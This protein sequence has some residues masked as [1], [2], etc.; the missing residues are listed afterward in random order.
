MAIVKHYVLSFE[1]SVDEPKAVELLESSDY[2]KQ[3]LAQLAV[4]SVLDE[5]RSK[6]HLVPLY[7]EHEGVAG[8]EHPLESGDVLA[9]LLLSTVQDLDL[10]VEL[11]RKHVV[12]IEVCVAPEPKD[13][14][15][16]DFGSYG[17]V[18]ALIPVA[19][20]DA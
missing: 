10:A 8:E 5:I 1:V 13:H 17:L 14:V 15:D 3:Y 11:L 12:Q 16:T 2:L 18:E 7:V 19:L 4:V 9:I 6:V 20:F